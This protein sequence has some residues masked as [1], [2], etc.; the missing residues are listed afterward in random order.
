MPALTLA[1][2]SVPSVQSTVD[3]APDGSA[4]VIVEMTCRFDGRQPKMQLALPTSSPSTYVRLNRLTEQSASFSGQIPDVIVTRQEGELVVRWSPRA[5]DETRHYVIDYTVENAVRRYDDLARITLPSIPR[6]GGPVDRARIELHLPKPTRT[7]ELKDSLPIS[8]SPDRRSAVIERR[9]VPR[10]NPLWLDIV[11]DAD[12]FAQVPKHPGR[13][14]ESEQRVTASDSYPFGPVTMVPLVRPHFILV[15]LL[16]PLPLLGV[17]YLAYGREPRVPGQGQY[18]HEPPGRIPPL[19]V[20]P[21]MRQQPDLTE[22]PEQTLDATLA[23]LL[24]AARRGALEIVP[25]DARTGQGRGF[26]L[27]QLDKLKEL[28]DLS[29]R[30][31]SYYFECVGAGRNIVTA[32]DIRRHAAEQPEGFLA[33]LKEMSIGGRDWWWQNL[34]VDFLEPRSSGAYQFFCYSSIALTALAGF[35]L[36]LSQ[37]YSVLRGSV[38]LGGLLGI[39]SGFLAGIVYGQLGRVILRWSPPA[40]HEHQRWQRFRRFLVDFSA[41]EQAPI[42]LSAIW[43]EYYVYAVALGIGQKFMQGLADVAPKLSLTDGLLA[44]TS[45]S[46]GQALLTRW[47]SSSSAAVMLGQSIALLLDSFRTGSGV[48]GK[49]L[50]PMQQLFFWRVGHRGHV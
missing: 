14:M 18:E 44:Q 7:L 10:T 31:V 20:P 2:I 11:T 3:L 40:Y 43:Q 45:A 4:R 1:R 47:G 49:R 48:I 6:I 33:W 5:S 32:E 38:R 27:A 22:L 15:L 35:L 34:K 28:D 50:D 17:L 19:A 30:V 39:A 26:R 23:T 29:R 12:L 37:S 8:V 24:D 46:T 41:I 13:L 16:L 36:P 42:G 21:I 9:D 25:G